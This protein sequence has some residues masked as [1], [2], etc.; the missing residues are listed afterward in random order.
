VRTRTSAVHLVLRAAPVVAAAVL[1]VGLAGFAVGA[2]PGGGTGPRAGPAAVGAPPSTSFTA[3]LFWDGRDTANAS[4]AGAA[5]PTSFASVASL[6]YVWRA[7]GGK[8]GQPVPYNVTTATVSVEYLGF[9]VLGRSVVNSRAAPASSGFFN[10]SWDASQDYYLLEGLYRLTAELTAS[11]G[12][13][14]WS[15]AFYVRADGP[16]HLAVLPVGLAVL[17]AVELASIAA[18]PGRLRGRT[19][20]PASVPAYPAASRPEERTP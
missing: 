2:G 9:S 1:A 17:I 6:E 11:N 5:I 10:L 8:L 14:V 4:S 15:E 20:P 12:S 13:V 3:Q 19:P 7:R 18:L 16:Y